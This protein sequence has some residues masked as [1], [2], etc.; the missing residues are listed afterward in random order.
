M[1]TGKARKEQRPTK[2]NFEKVRDMKI[3]GEQ[4]EHKGT[5]CIQT[6]ET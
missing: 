1:K 5:K 4:V 3:K 6:G 2:C